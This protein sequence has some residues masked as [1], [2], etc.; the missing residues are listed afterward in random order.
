MRNLLAKPNK[1]NITT[2]VFSSSLVFIGIDLF[3]NTFLN[4]NFTRFTK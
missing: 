2:F 4:I 1:E 3:A